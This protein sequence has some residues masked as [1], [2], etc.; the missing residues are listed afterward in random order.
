MNT[1]K[2]A[3]IRFVAGFVLEI[4]ML[5][6]LFYGIEISSVILAM[7]FGLMGFDLP[8]IWKNMKK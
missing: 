5:L 6:M 1:P 7:P 2:G 8:D 3:L 4:L